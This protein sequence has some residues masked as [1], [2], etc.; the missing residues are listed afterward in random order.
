MTYNTGDFQG[1]YTLLDNERHILERSIDGVHFSLCGVEGNNP[2]HPGFTNMNKCIT[3]RQWYCPECVER[4][5]LRVGLEEA[6]K[7]IL[8]P[9]WLTV[10]KLQEMYGLD[11]DEAKEKLIADMAWQF[12]KVAEL[13]GQEEVNHEEAP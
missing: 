6:M 1:A 7:H 9:E 10:E 3:P 11:K 8:R 12:N 2:W 4:W 13:F 5:I